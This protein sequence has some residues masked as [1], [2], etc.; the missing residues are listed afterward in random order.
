[1]ITPRL[2]GTEDPTLSSTS[3]KLDPKS[4]LYREDILL[5]KL[6]IIIVSFSENQIKNLIQKINHT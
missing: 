3:L 6:L 1:M 2:I 4:V 5:L